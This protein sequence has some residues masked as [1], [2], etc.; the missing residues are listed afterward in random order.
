MTNMQQK[1]YAMLDTAKGKMGSNGGS[2]MEHCTR[3]ERKFDLFESDLPDIKPN[4]ASEKRTS[5][6]L[7]ALS[8]LGSWNPLPRRI[9]ERDTVWLFDNTA[10][11]STNSHSWKA[12]F[13]AAVFNQDSGVDVSKV[14]ADIA[15]KLGIAKG[16]AAEATIRERL[17]PFVQQILPGRVVEI[18]FGVQKLK[19]SLGPGGRNAISSDLK[20]LPDRTRDEVATSVAKVPQGTDGILEMKTLYAEQEGWGVISGRFLSIEI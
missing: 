20:S 12:E 14:V 7:D 19:F 15:G 4:T 10:Y 6:G 5:L 2:Y 9:T 13:V 16:D 11:R 17:R 18:D 1:G 3:R 8:S